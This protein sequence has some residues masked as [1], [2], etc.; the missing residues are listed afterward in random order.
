MRWD[1]A[2]ILTFSLA[3]A[4]ERA[5]L[6]RR[7][8]RDDLDPIAERQKQRNAVAVPTFA[9]TVQSCF[10]AR[11]AELKDDGKAGRDAGSHPCVPT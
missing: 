6:A 5:S 1:W 4:R 9:E 8:V 10:L 3:E 11:Q 2:A 7:Q